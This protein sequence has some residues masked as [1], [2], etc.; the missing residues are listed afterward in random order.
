MK[1]TKRHRIGIL[2]VLAV[3]LAGITTGNLT[4]CDVFFGSPMPADNISVT[5]KVGE[6]AEAIR[7]Q[8]FAPPEYRFSL[9]G[10]IPAGVFYRIRRTWVDEVPAI[11]SVDLVTTT[12]T[13]PGHYLIDYVEG[14]VSAIPTQLFVGQVDLTVE[15]AAPSLIA[16][17]NYFVEGP[18][19]VNQHVNFTAYCSSAPAGQ[20]IVQ[21]KWWFDYSGGPTSAPSDTTSEFQ[22]DHTYLTAGQRTVRLV[23]VSSNGDE[24]ATAQPIVVVAP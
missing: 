8:S 17:F 16:C 7:V 3:L 6:T 23:V 20:T 5:V 19:L 12:T 10:S 11:A 21:Y 24:A 22:I 1:E 15:E 2:L 18:I 9:C 14:G 4:V 13:P